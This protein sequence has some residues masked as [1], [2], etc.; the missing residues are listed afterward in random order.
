MEEK[1]SNPYKEMVAELA[2]P[3]EEILSSLT[4]AKFSL[5]VDALQRGVVTGNYVD[6]VKKQVIY[7]K[8]VELITDNYTY[9][10]EVTPEQCHLIHMSMGLLGEAAEVIEAL[11]GHVLL[12]HPLDEINLLEELGDIEFYMEGFRQGIEVN[13]EDVLQANI[14]KLSTGENA[15]YKGGYSDQA[16]Q[17]R[18]DK[19]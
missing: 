10:P 13:R 3:G 15:R 12:G 17:N 18:A 14:N 9:M 8:P 2:K 7:N 5:L 1:E 19:A 16:A 4:T 11:I 6:K